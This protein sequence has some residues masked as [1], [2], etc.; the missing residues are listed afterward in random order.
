MMGG[1]LR[2]VMDPKDNN[3]GG[4]GSLSTTDMKK[5]IKPKSLQRSDVQF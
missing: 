2:T 4:L 5:S 1:W 3:K